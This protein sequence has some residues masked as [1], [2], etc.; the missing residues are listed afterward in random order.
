MN[1]PKVLSEEIKYKDDWMKII[2]AKLQFENGKTAEWTYPDLNDAV[3]I[4]AA[5]SEKNIY[6]VKEWR[7]PFRKY[8]LE[9]PIGGCSAKDE[10]GI[11]KQAR[12]ELME[13]IGFDCKK[14][15][16]LCPPL[17]TGRSRIK[18][19][20]FL[21]TDLFVSKKKA[22]ENE[23][24]EVLKMH[25]GDAIKLFT[26]KEETTPATLAGLFLANERLK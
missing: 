18:Y 12:E 7:L 26:V 4:V 5:D 3:V 1:A 16:R 23:Y 8:L 14:I 17:V 2:S 9:L 20:L 10:A 21:A 19:H 11:I 15:V 22:D 24:I 13:E 25:L 6:L